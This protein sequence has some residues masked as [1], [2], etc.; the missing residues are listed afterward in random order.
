MSA[1]EEAGLI[2][3]A[4]ADVE[5]ALSR[6]ADLLASFSPFD[7]GALEQTID[8]FLGE[9]GDLG[10]VLS[11]LDVTAS[12][13]AEPMA[14][15]GAVAVFETVRRRVRGQSDEEVED[16]EGDGDAGPPG[17]PGLPRRLGP[18]GT[19][20]AEHLDELLERLNGGDEAAAEQVFRT[21]EPYL[22]IA[23]PPP[24]PAG[25]CGPSSTRWTSCS[26]SGPTSWR[27]S[28]RPAGTSPTAP[29]SRRSSPGWRGTG[30]STAAASTAGA[31]A[32]RSR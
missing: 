30:S 1:H 18:G 19:M 27:G 26:R 2:D 8:R 4:I 6:G 20:S 24:A 11:N 29:T 17:L 15:A 13:I 5:A 12:L 3:G 32:A 31:L 22:R 23:R 9:V 25:P 21:Y 16:A 28:A 10:A 14:A 7:R